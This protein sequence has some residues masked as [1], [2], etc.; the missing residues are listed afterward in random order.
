MSAFV[1]VIAFAFA[2]GPYSQESSKRGEESPVVSQAGCS[3]SS[4]R[5]RRGEA[6]MNVC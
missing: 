1:F 2:R 6:R 4:V 5:C 3:V